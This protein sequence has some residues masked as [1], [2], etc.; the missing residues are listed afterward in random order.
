MFS[1]STTMTAAVERGMRSASVEF[2]S[3]VIGQLHSEGVL[4]CSLDD[5]LKMFDFD[6]VKVVSSRSKASK[7]RE[8]GKSSKVKKVSSKITAKPAVVLPFCGEI[9]G[10]WCKGVKFSH[11]LH[12]QCTMGPSGEDTYCKTCR[13]HADNSATG[14]PPY[15]D[16]NDRAEFNVDYRD[17]KGKLTLPYANVVEKLGISMEAAVT[18]AA[19]LGWTIPAEQLVKRTSKRGRPAKSAAVSD[20]DSDTEE[21]KKR[22]RPSKAKVAAPT[23]EDQIAQLVAEAYAETTTKSAVKVKKLKVKKVALTTEQKASAKL[24]KKE[25]ALKLK[26]EKKEAADNL[27]AEKAAANLAKKEAAL[28][29]KAE[30]KEAADNLKAEKAAALVARKAISLKL[31]EDKAAALVAKK[32]A[33]LKVKEEKLV[34]KAL[35]KEAKEAAALKVKSEKK[36][37]ALKVRQE[38][39]AA[40][41]AEREAAK[42]RKK[43]AADKLKAENADEAEVDVVFPELEEEKIADIN[44][45]DEEEKIAEIDSSDDE[46]G[47]CELS[48]TMTVGGIEYYFSEQDGQTVLFSKTGEPVGV[49][50][51][52]TDTVQECEFDEE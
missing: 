8:S 34:A 27:K 1:I 48:E 46:D 10:D 6:S 16:I 22:G 37:L 12:T 15:G 23:Q 14:K 20:S 36:A 17:P 44:S 25:A 51:A 26:A 21:T 4:K 31:K 40:K 50:D 2:A 42:L 9:Q 13:K 7:K 5:A 28:K 33:A 41:K 35:E 43:E 52:D 39:A 47:E 49:Y 29:L 32:E 19:T 24:A 18:A 38:K 11:G 45:S 30:K 3:E